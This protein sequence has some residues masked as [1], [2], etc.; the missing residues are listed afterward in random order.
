MDI[1]I[2]INIAYT[3]TLRIALPIWNTHFNWLVSLTMLCWPGSF[4]T[5]DSYLSNV[6]QYYLKK[7]NYTF[8]ELSTF[9]I[10]IFYKICLCLWY[11]YKKN[12]SRQMVLNTFL[13]LY[14]FLFISK[15]STMLFHLLICYTLWACWHILQDFI[16]L[17]L[18][19][20]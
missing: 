12:L 16:T 8:I 3:W 10:Q 1:K 20:F 4:Q 9:F 2:C 13:L 11:R 14:G 15:I 18:C 17:F 19:I 7:S 6:N 5:R